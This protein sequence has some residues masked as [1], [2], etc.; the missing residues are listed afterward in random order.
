MYISNLII[1]DKV[2][3]AITTSFKALNTLDFSPLLHCNSILFCLLYKPFF[4]FFKEL[5]SSPY[6]TLDRNPKLPIF[7]P[8]IGISLYPFIS[9]ATLSIVPSPP[10]T[11]TRSISSSISLDASS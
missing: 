6:S 9:R 2:P 10:K 4:I 8:K 5:S 1:L 11:I 3:L 7:T